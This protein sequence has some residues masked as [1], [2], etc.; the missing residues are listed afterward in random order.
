MQQVQILQKVDIDE[1]STF[2]IVDTKIA[3][4]K[5]AI[6]AT[7][8]LWSRFLCVLV[9][10]Q[11]ASPDQVSAYLVENCPFQESKTKMALY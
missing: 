2:Q 3:K 6:K 8:N 9:H 7:G 4:D 11:N 10:W 5:A 1:Y